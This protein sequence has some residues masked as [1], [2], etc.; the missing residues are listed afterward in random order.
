MHRA[1]W[2]LALI[3]L[4]LGACGGDD[5]DGGGGGGGGHVS[6]GLDSNKPLAGLTAEEAQSACHALSSSIGQALPDEDLTRYACT[7]FGAIFSV[8]SKPDGTFAIDEA[9]CEG[10]VDDC[11]ADARAEPATTQDECEA[12]TVSAELMSCTATVGELEACL[13]AAIARIRSQ[14]DM[15]SC[16]SPVSSTLPATQEMPALPACAQVEAKCPGLAEQL[17]PEMESAG[18]GGGFVDV[19][20][21][22]PGGCSDTCVEATDGLCDDGGADSDFSGCDYGTDCTDCGERPAN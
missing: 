16:D 5:G 14:L 1:T 19:E 11:I 6:S 2:I 7:L 8:Q 21:T 15:V 13:D 3:C 12:G 22:G 10:M 18:S 17:T 4:Q 9:A 20:P